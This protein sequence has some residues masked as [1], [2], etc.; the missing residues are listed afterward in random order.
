[1]A[2]HVV[3]VTR[4]LEQVLKATFL[5]FVPGGVKSPVLFGPRGQLMCP[6]TGEVGALSPAGW[7]RGCH[8]YQPTRGSPFL[9]CLLFK[10]AADREAGACVR[11]RARA[12]VHPVTKTFKPNQNQTRQRGFL[13]SSRSGS[14]WNPGHLGTHL[15]PARARG[16]GGAGDERGRGPV[17]QCRSRR[18]FSPC[19]VLPRTARR[20]GLR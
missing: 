13:T 12:C 20:E 14:E 6:E 3:V 16:R 10:A 1:M 11:V 5:T 9:P 2:L 15:S 7:G 18:T 17:T 8:G 19:S 4:A